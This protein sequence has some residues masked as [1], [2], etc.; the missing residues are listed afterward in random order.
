M[1]AEFRARYWL[2]QNDPPIDPA[3]IWTKGRE[4]TA[5]HGGQGLR[6]DITYRVQAVL[7][8][9]SEVIASARILEVLPSHRYEWILVGTKP[10]NAR[11]VFL[12]RLT[13]AS[14]L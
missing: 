13:S 8:G 3:A 4:R 7:P 10:G 14:P 5:A 9:T 12:D 2:W 1:A 6:T 11:F